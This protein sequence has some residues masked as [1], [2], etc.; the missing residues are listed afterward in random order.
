MRDEIALA[1][2]TADDLKD[3][4]PF[5]WERRLRGD[6]GLELLSHFVGMLDS[7]AARQRSLSV[8]N[9]ATR[10]RTVSALLANLLAGALNRV[11]P[12]RFLALSFNRNDY[13]GT[14]LSLSVMVAMRE[15]LKSERLVHA[16]VGYFLQHQMEGFNRSSLTRLRPTVA[17]LD[18]F[19]AHA[20]DRR[21]VLSPKAQLVRLNLPNDHV[22]AEGDV[23][24]ASRATLARVNALLAD[25]DMA[26]SDDVWDR[27]AASQPEYADMTRD[28]RRRRQHAGDES[29]KA[30]YR[31]F[32]GNWRR[33]GRLY[34]GWWQSAK[35]EHRAYITINGLT[36][37][38]LDYVQL[39]PALL[40]ARLPRS[41]NI[42]AYIVPGWPPETRPLGKSTFA[43]LLN[44]AASKSKP[45]V[46]L[47]RAPTKEKHLLPAG[48]DFR[49]YE[50]AYRHH[51]SDY[52]EWFNI[53]EGMK[54]QL[55]DSDLALSILND[56]AYH[57]IAALPV[58]DSFIVQAQ[59][60][61]TLR[62]TMRDQFHKSPSGKWLSDIS[63]L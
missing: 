44:K 5:D 57:G 63:R 46:S 28:E 3:S 8:A 62:A 6:D 27:E 23:I 13:T 56:L 49:D 32:T 37:V 30:L 19:A 34:G 7:N 10:D 39:H 25:A 11:N 51:M 43:R 36:T 15:L 33:G 61:E 47:G 48:T 52:A 24:T 1:E 45:S 21:S 31:V 41:P 18:L 42:D 53:D 59:H 22:G 35:K 38:E 54:L 20:V 16:K 40:R 12:R 29:A 17:L 14:G 60:E 50:A 58:H 26:L 9:L 2:I 55:E 4:F